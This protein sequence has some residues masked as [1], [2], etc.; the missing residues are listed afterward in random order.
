MMGGVGPGEQMPYRPPADDDRAEELNDSETGTRVDPL[1]GALLGGRFKIIEPIA[2]GGMGVIYRAEQLPLGRQCAVKTM[3]PTFDDDLTAEFHRRFFMEASVAAKL[4]HPNTVAVFD[5]G[6]EGTLYYI[7]MEFVQGKTLKQV[8]EEEGALASDRAVRIAI[9]IARSLREAHTHGVVHRD[10][11]PANVA[12]VDDGDEHDNIKVFDF[13][14]VKSVKG[15]GADTVTTRGL[16]LG[17]PTYM[18]P[19]QVDGDVVSPATDIY[20]LGIVL[21]EMLSG[22]PPFVKASKYSLVMAHLS[23]PPPL[24]S[25]VMD[26]EKLPRG[27]DEVVSRCLEKDPGD[28][29]QGLDELL[30]ELQRIAQGKAPLS[31]SAMRKRRSSGNAERA[32]KETPERL[33]SDT[34]SCTSTGASVFDASGIDLIDKKPRRPFGVWIAAGIAALGVLGAGLFFTLRSS[35]SSDSRSAV[36][37]PPSTASSADLAATL[38]ASPPLIPTVRKVRIEST[39]EGASVVMGSE[40]HETRL[41]AATPCEIELPASAGGPQSHEIKLSLEGYRPAAVRVAPSEK[42]L[43]VELRRVAAERGHGSTKA[44]A[45]GVFRVDPY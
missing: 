34:P 8:I 3:R 17:S 7:A 39:P 24:L 14:L 2:R 35:P 16:C 41:C 23:E 10:L 18:A 4:T 15:A 29:F 1:V 13:G 27:L 11:K 33:S 9:E 42:S 21:F 40:G 6:N 36:A 20:S 5:Y 26:T 30:A 37:D 44:T 19:E 22:R 12:I 45:T 43:R 31:T 32:V 25:E 38:V 28:R